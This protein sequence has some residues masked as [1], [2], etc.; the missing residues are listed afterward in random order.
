MAIQFNSV[1]FKVSKE[2]IAIVD[3]V[4]NIVKLIVNPLKT[5]VVV[6]TTR[7]N[8]QQLKDVTHIRY[9]DHFQASS[10][11]SYQ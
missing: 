2:L 4:A 11:E 3:I 7:R 1:T 5:R 6:F 10:R 9:Q 8:L